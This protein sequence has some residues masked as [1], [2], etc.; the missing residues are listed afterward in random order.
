MAIKSSLFKQ[1]GGFIWAAGA[2]AALLACSTTTPPIDAVS[3]AEQ[4]LNRAIEAQAGTYAP[5]ELRL[6]REKLDQAKAALREQDKEHYK[7]ARRLAEQAGV[8]ARLA[9]AKAQSQVARQE[10]QAIRETI[11]SLEREADQRSIGK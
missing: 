2:A 10:A 4:A 3:T 9:E 5:L 8:T 11:D 6:S 7:D 1:C